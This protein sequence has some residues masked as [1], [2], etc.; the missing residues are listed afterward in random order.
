MF[1]HSGKISRMPIT[2]LHVKKFCE[3]TLFRPAFVSFLLSVMAMTGPSARPTLAQSSRPRSAPGIF[4][5]GGPFRSE[6]AAKA[7]KLP[8]KEDLVNQIKDAWVKTAP[9]SLNIANTRLVV[10]GFTL[11]SDGTIAG[12][13]VIVEKSS[14]D[15][16]IDEAGVRAAAPFQKFP[17]NFE[18]SNIQLHVTFDDDTAHFPPQVAG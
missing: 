9:P 5:T 12:D 2:N 15:S 3:V 4:V 8:P 17:N 16:A 6:A 18:P 13:K 10:V 7:F 14:G 1:H 11:K